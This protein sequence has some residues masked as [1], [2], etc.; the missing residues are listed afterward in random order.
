[1]IKRF[2]NYRN[3]SISKMKEIISYKKFVNESNI[4][5]M[6]FKVSHLLML[7]KE[8]DR[9]FKEMN[10]LIVGMT[11]SVSSKHSEKEIKVYR[12]QPTNAAFLPWAEY[13]ENGECVSDENKGYMEIRKRLEKG[14]NIGIGMIYGK[15][16]SN[17]EEKVKAVH[18]LNSE[19]V[20]KILSEPKRVFSDVDPL[21]E[22][23]WED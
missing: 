23:D 17:P 13:D 11:I 20:I 1:M 5:G 9:F 4:V 15:L 21:G 14:D 18:L 10:D 16:T 8:R 19:N 12:F 2:N 22:E 6:E 3:E 7:F